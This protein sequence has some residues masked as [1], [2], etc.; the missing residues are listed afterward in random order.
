M[1]RRGVKM[2]ERLWNQA[3]TLERAPLTHTK[4]LARFTVSIHSSSHPS[5]FLC[6]QFEHLERRFLTPMWTSM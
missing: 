1:M 5:C 4:P 6:F 3:A 2:A